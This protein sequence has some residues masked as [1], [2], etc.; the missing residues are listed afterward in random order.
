MEYSIGGFEISRNSLEKRNA[1]KSPDPRDYLGFPLILKNF[2]NLP[3]YPRIEEYW[4][5]RGSIK[6]IDLL[7]RL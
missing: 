3:V 5:F 2:L 4:G 7:D 6:S 1:S